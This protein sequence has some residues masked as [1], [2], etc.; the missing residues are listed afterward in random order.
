MAAVV[1]GEL[2]AS[3]YKLLIDQDGVFSNGAISISPSSIDIPNQK[4]YFPARLY[5]FNGLLFHPWVIQEFK[6]V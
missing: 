1:L 5:C 4:M 6:Q 3:D 2:N